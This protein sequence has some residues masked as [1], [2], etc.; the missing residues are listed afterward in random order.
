[1]RGGLPGCRSLKNLY[2][3]VSDKNPDKV[4]KFIGERT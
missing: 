4:Q 3:S 2:F 1:M